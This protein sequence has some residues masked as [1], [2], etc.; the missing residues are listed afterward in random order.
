MLQEDGL[1]GLEAAALVQ[2]STWFPY[3]DDDDDLMTLQ[4]MLQLF[5]VFKTEQ[6]KAKQSSFG[7]ENRTLEKKDCKI[8]SG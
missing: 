7:K 5:L 4:Y 2:G 1:P 8:G 3:N 6:N